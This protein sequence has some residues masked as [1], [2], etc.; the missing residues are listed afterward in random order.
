MERNFKLAIPLKPQ[1]DVRPIRAR[2]VE[3]QF[4]ALGEI[5]ACLAPGQM[6]DLHD[7]VE[8][9]QIQGR[10]LFLVH[11]FIELIEDDD[12]PA[13]A[14]LDP[15]HGHVRE[16]GRDIVS[17]QCQGGADGVLLKAHVLGQIE[18][19]VRAAQLRDEDMLQKTGLPGPV[20][21]AQVQTCVDG[22]RQGLA[23]DETQARMLDGIRSGGKFKHGRPW[24][25]ARFESW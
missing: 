19:A 18:Q 6:R 15:G 9:G 2:P 3:D 7:P 23:Q 16:S 10:H 12:L 14:G 24:A 17:E 11:V 5:R 25:L 1:D 21:S 20:F 4:V 22:Q 8:S 13:A